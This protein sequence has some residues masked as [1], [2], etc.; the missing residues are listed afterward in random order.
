MIFGKDCFPKHLKLS[1]SEG[2][3]SKNARFGT[4]VVSFLPRLL[5]PVVQIKDADKL[6]NP[7]QLETSV[8]YGRNKYS[9]RPV[10]LRHLQNC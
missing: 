1:I 4:A 5:K 8:A 7:S 6:A 9:L 10:P 2:V 3:A